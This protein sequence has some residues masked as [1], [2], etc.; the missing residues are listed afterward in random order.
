MEMRALNTFEEGCLRSKEEAWTWKGKA[1]G[2]RRVRTQIDY[3]MVGPTMHGT[4]EALRR[5]LPFKSDHRPVLG[6]LVSLNQVPFAWTT[7]RGSTLKGWEPADLEE[8]A[9]SRTCMPSSS[10]GCGRER[11][12]AHPEA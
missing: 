3:V 12:A 8:E 5:K 7:Y 10:G 4:A 1:A 11:G 9:I 6:H 2:G